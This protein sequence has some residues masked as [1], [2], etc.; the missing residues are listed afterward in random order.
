MKRETMTRL[1]REMSAR[2]PIDVADYFTHDF[3]LHDPNAPEIASG[4]SGA[5]AMIDSIMSW[6]PD[7]T[8]DIVDTME[9]G[10][11]IAVRWRLRGTHK[12]SMMEASILA[13]YRFHEGRIAE[14][15]GIGARAP[16]P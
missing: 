7:L 13:I 1:A 15:W 16:W 3:R 11:R 9:D 12:G 6:A 14:D 4:L 2:R 5:R 10:D 8:L